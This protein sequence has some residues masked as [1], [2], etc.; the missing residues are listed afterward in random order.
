MIADHLFNKRSFWMI[1]SIAG[2]DNARTNFQ[3]EGDG[4]AGIERH[5]LIADLNFHCRAGGIAKAELDHCGLRLT[6]DRVNRRRNIRRSG[7][8]TR[9]CKQRDSGNGDSET[10]ETLHR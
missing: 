3:V 9:N 5:Y 7:I 8:D 4:L 6:E 10:I 1:W 2:G